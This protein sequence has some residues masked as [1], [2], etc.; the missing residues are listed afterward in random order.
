MVEALLKHP[1][2]VR[3]I[4]EADAEE[5]SL[6]IQLPFLQVMLPNFR[7][8]PV[9]MG[10]Q[11]FEFCEKLAQVIAD[12]SRE[13]RLLLIASSDLSH[14][15][16]AS[17]ARRL[18]RVV[19]DCVERF[20]PRRLADHLHQGDCEA[21]GAGPMMTV[22][23]ASRLRGANKSRVL[24]YANSGDVTGDTRRVVGYLAAAFYQNPGSKIAGLP[25]GR[26]GRIGVDLGLS[27]EEKRTLREV[28]TQAIR[29]RCRGEPLPK[30][31]AVSGNLAQHR[32]AFVCLR[33][34]S[35]LRGCIGMIEGREPLIDTVRDMAV[36]A[37]FSDPRFCAVREDELDDL[38]VEISVLTPLER[39]TDPERI[40]IGTHGLYI[41]QGHASGLLLPQVAVE[42]G[43]DRN[44]FLEWTCKK[45]GLSSKAWKKPE[46]EIYIFSADVF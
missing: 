37:A 5:H 3:Y 2:L 17:D 18:D 38:H 27:D 29:S 45:A 26:R 33:K 8:T 24:H 19:I 14:Y 34:G 7:M 15:H 6:E 12:A 39:I 11:S 41:K 42:Q 23:I 10:E 9:V 1:D 4:P 25:E 16:S 44:Q 40:M 32:G 43:W 36:Q 30:T 22:M 46:T 21:C 13:T 35:E 31:K 20:D 28:A